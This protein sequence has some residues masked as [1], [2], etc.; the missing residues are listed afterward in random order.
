MIP[1][2]YEKL[3]WVYWDQGTTV[4]NANLKGLDWSIELVLH[5]FKA[6]SEENPRELLESGCGPIGPNQSS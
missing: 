6:L 2:Y 1:S 4:M 5:F 3:C